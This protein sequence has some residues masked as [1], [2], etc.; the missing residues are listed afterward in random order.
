MDVADDV[1]L[2]QAQQVIIALQVRGPVCEALAAVIRLFQLVPLDHG[3][4][5]AIQE[6]DTVVQ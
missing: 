4:H 1:R 6:E 3:A 5:G 2:G